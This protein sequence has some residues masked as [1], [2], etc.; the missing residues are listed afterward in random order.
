MEERLVYDV[1]M[2][3]GQDTAYYLHQGCR[4]VAV[5]AN[6]ILADQGMRRFKKD[7]DLGLLHIENAGVS[8]Q[9]S[10]APFWICDDKSEWSSFDVSVASRRG[11]KHHAI[12]IP[13]VTLPDLFR[14][15]GRPCYVKLGVKGSVEAC[16][17]QIATVERPPYVSAESEGPQ[18]VQR[19]AELG[20][21]QFKVVDQVCFCSLEVPPTLAY[22]AYWG[23]KKYCETSLYCREAVI[24]RITGKLG[25]RK[26]AETILDR[27]Q[28][29]RGYRFEEGSSGPWGEDAP[30]R[31]T[32]QREA[33]EALQ[34][35]NER[36]RANGEAAEKRW[37]DVHAKA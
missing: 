3:T 23:L 4:V 27:Y 26:L 16:L 15:F 30:G 6:P 7:L 5:E 29:F 19:L 10:L 31:W 22:S 18:T 24:S 2:H 13:V 37:F 35:F 9:G 14:K 17:K 8:D 36:R 11:Y 28:Q 1:G 25:G 12:T 20:Y 34:R 32:S 33:E 21:R